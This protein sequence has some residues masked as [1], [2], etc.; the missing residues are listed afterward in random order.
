MLFLI[1]ITSSRIWS[2]ECSPTGRFTQELL[3]ALKFFSHYCHSTSL[4]EFLKLLANDYSACQTQMENG[5]KAANVVDQLNYIL[6][7][8]EDIKGFLNFAV[9]VEGINVTDCISGRGSIA[10][11]E[12]LITN[13]LASFTI[14]V[15]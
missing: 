1:G 4:Y 7:T 8:S 15:C 13:P 3:C 14:Q 2:S 12:L 5:F 9:H 11:C 10:T 6:Q